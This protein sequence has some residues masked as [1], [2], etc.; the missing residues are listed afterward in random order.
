[1]IKILTG[2][3]YQ[4]GS[5]TRLPINGNLNAISQGIMLCVDGSPRRQE[6]KAEARADKDK[7]DGES[8]VL[9][10]IAALQE[11]DRAL[12]PSGSMPSS[13]PAH[14]HSRRKPGTG[15]PRMPGMARSVC[16]LPKR[17][18]VQDEV[19]DVRLQRRGEARRRQPVAGRL[20]AQGVD[21]RRRGQDQRAREE[22]GKRRINK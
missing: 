18:E 6:L 11:P 2:F 5:I 8:A 22:S 3:R 12:G 16:F 20:R 1:L 10:A 19:C 15:C 4:A 17:A 9:A 13:K 21:C 14:G 7:A